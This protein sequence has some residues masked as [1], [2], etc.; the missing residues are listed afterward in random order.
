MLIHIPVDRL[1]GGFH[2]DPHRGSERWL[3]FFVQPLYQP[4]EAVFLTWGWRIPRLEASL[5]TSGIVSV[6][7]SPD[8]I[9]TTIRVMLEEGIPTLMP[10]LT[11]EG[12]FD[13]LALHEDLNL[14]A[15]DE[16]FVYTAALLGRYPEALD[17]IESARVRGNWPSTGGKLVG[18]QPF[19]YERRIRL[20]KV[21]DL[22]KA[23]AYDE[24]NAQL[25][26][27]QV[28]SMARFGIEDLMLK[29][30]SSS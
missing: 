17:R 10:A 9:D 29:R 14:Q 7:G 26:L 23:A 22:L 15:S 8:E 4:C 24:I 27:W 25:A 12:F 19:Q 28:E 20:S 2:F 1:L 21:E 18:E 13:F 30:E 5:L 3:H 6:G 11:T 16:P